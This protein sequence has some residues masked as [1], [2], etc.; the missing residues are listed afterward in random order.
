MP[1]LDG[2]DCARTGE[3]TG[4]A[5]GLR[6]ATWRSTRPSGRRDRTVDCRGTYADIRGQI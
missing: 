5:G 3:D 4:A 1:A 2:P 6:S